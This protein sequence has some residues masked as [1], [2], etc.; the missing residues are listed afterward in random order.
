MEAFISR[1][2][3]ASWFSALDA[4]VENDVCIVGGGPSGLV[5]AGD[6]A[7]A[8]Y[9]VSLFDRKLAPG[10]GM[11]GGAMMFSRIV[12]QDE[13]VGILQEAGV[14]CD[15]VG[16][17]CHVMDSVEATSA[18]I[19][20]AT[21]AG[22]RIFNCFSVEDVVLD[23]SS[24]VGGLVV[25]WAPVHREGMHVDPLMIL[26]RVT[27]DGTGHD[28]EVANVLVRK[29]GVRLDT[30]DGGVRGEES[31]KVEDGERLTVEHTRCVYPGLYVC[32]MA[33]NAVHGGNRMGPIFGGMVLS[34]RKT[35]RLIQEELGAPRGIVRR[36]DVVGAGGRHG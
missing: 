33:A 26:S 17:G 13:A 35:S 4:A 29:N 5:A 19:Y 25:N 32:G 21:H 22:A 15:P 11:W 27:V 36:D 8:G 28:A 24:R 31:L 30:P 20:R 14:R 2:I 9:S 16:G 7:R 3:A 18:L 23:D 1:S 34:G 6:L 12:V 10:G